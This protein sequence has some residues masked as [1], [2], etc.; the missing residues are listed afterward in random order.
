MVKLSSLP[1]IH[2]E[3]LTARNVLTICH[4]SETLSAS[5]RKVVTDNA[6]SIA[7]GHCSENV[8]MRAIYEDDTPVGFIM[9]HIGSDWADGIDCTGVF[10]WRLMIGGAFQGRGYGWA[11]MQNLIRHLKSLGVRELFT[12]YALGESSPE[13]FYQRLG[14]VATGDHY[15]E[16]PEVVLK[17]D[18]F[19]PGSED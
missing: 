2:F 12:S 6:V 13:G 7:Q 3:R 8:W 15:G 5:Q 11:A 4:L 1:T 14:F 19:D 10:L 18:D 9:L 16:E 17:L